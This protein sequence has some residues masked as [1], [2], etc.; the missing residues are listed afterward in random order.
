MRQFFL[1]MKWRLNEYSIPHTAAS[2][3][4]SL[5]AQFFTACMSNALIVEFALRAAIGKIPVVIWRS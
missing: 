1:I 4:R 5:P 2:K 3:Q